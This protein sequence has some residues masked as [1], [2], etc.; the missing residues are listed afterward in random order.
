MVRAQKKL[1]T[2]ALRLLYQAGFLRFF[3]K[4]E[5]THFWS[6]ATP[7]ITQKSTKKGGT[8]YQGIF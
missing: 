7:I 8:F 3:R 4:Y 5:N 1:Q 2:T 6:E